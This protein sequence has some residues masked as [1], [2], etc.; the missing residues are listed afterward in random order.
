M[1]GTNEDGRSEASLRAES[2]YNTELKA[3]L[4]PEENGKF[5]MVDANSFDFEVDSNLVFAYVHLMDR[6]PD[7]E[8][9]IFKI[10]TGEHWRSVLH[11]KRMTHK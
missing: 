4:E 9:F 5:I 8:L 1:N 3:K 2:F 7:G 10:G 6:Q 11:G